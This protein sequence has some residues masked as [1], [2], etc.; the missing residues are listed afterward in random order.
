LKTELSRLTDLIAK[1]VGEHRDAHPELVDV[2]QYFI[3]FRNELLPLTTREE[4]VLFPA[5]RHLERIADLATN[6]AEDAIYLVD[7]EIVRHCRVAASGQ[8]EQS[9]QTHF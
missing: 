7:G 6:L 2:Q 3:T 9:N 5:I 1:V 8:Q 4:D